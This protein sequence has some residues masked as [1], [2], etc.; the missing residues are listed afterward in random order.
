MGGLKGVYMPDGLNAYQA[1]GETYLVTANEGDAREWGLDKDGNEIEGVYYTDSVRVKNLADDGY[2]PVC[3]DSPLAALTGDADL[4]RLNVT[5]ENGFN[6]AKECYDE[7]YAF[8]S[9]SFSIWSTDGEQVFDSGDAFEQITAA[10]LPEFF[11]SNHTES[12]F[13]GR[14]D[15]KGPE[16]ENLTIGEV[17]GRTYAFVGFERVGGIAVFD[18]TD[19]AASFFVTYVNNRDFSVSVEDADDKAAAL[20]QAGDLG[21][22]GLA[23]IPASSSPNGAALLAVAN[24][25]SGTT[26]LFAIADAL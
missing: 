8:G 5:I 2:G 24:E 11:N 26:T 19:P 15:D 10:A 3:A 12:N 9:R 4:G 21:P 6:E 20:T 16:P 25:V 17:D 23:F 7:L 18:I 1:A 22:E 14:S 13:E